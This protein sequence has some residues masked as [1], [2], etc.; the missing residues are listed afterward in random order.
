MGIETEKIKRGTAG[1]GWLRRYTNASQ[2]GNLKFTFLIS[3]RRRRAAHA[4]PPPS[5]TAAVGHSLANL[6]INS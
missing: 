2:L 4:A 1:Q 3:W 6:A 5:L